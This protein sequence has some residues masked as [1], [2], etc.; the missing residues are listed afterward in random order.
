[1]SPEICKQDIVIETKQGKLQHIDQFNSKADPLHFVLPFIKGERGYG[2]NI[3]QKDGERNVSAMQYYSYRLQ[4]RDLEKIS[5]NKFGRLFQEYTVTM[6]SKIELQRLIYF[7]S[8]SGQKQ[9][10]AECYSGLEDIMH[11]E[12]FFDQH[13]NLRSCGRRIILP[14][15]FIGGPRNMHQLYQDAMGLIRKFGKPDLFITMTCNSNWPE[16]CKLDFQY[17]KICFKNFIYKKNRTKFKKNNFYETLVL[18]P[19]LDKEILFLI[20]K[21]VKLKIDYD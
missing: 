9:I 4:I 2:Y 16:I 10:R 18:Q 8:E 5:I 19:Y 12:N 20:L 21:K 14:S 3:Q 7:K 11:T 13:P 1:M 17:G 15:S 6:Y